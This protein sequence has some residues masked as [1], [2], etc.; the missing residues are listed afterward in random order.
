MYGTPILNMG[1]NKL[2]TSQIAY[3][4]QSPNTIDVVINKYWTQIKFILRHHHFFVD[5]YTH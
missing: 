4:I 2:G 3:S 1:Q 5:I